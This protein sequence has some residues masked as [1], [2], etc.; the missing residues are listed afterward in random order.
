VFL[1]GEIAMREHAVSRKG[2]PVLRARGAAVDDEV[3]EAREL[4]EDVSHARIAEVGE[5][6]IEEGNVWEGWH[7]EAGKQAVSISVL[8]DAQ[9][10]RLS[11]LEERR[12]GED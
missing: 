6:E 2:V 1:E 12:G 5:G 10:E 3:A 11:V 7:V 9:A 4:A 8:R